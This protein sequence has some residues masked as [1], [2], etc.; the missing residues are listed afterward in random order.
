VTFSA[1]A[2]STL[3][4]NAVATTRNIK[5]FIGNPIRRLLTIDKDI[6]KV[7]FTTTGGTYIVSISIGRL[8]KARKKDTNREAS[9]SS[10]MAGV[11]YVFG[12]A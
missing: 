10:S 8:S 11:Y 6:E 12:W 9:N 7:A 5:A 3:L 1:I 4:T 2:R